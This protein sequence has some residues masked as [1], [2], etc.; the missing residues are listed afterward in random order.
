MFFPLIFFAVMRLLRQRRG[1]VVA[2]LAVLA[3]GSLVWAE[4]A[5]AQNADVAF[6]LPQYRAWELL[7]GAIASFAVTTGR[8]WER[9]LPS[10]GLIA[11][12]AAA[13]LFSPTTTPAPGASMLVPVLGT[14]AV[15]VYGPSD[16]W[17]RRLLTLR[18][19]VFI[20]LISYSAYLVHQPV[21]AFIRVASLGEPNPWIFVAVLPLVIGLAWLSW[22]FIEVPFRD[23]NR[24]STRRLFAVLVPSMS[25][26]V[27]LGL[28]LHF[29]QGFPQRVFPHL[30]SQADV[31]VS[32]NERVRALTIGRSSAPAQPDIVVV[33]DSFGRDAVNALLEADPN[34]TGHIAY[35]EPENIRAP[36]T[37]ALVAQVQS[38]V[39]P[40]TMIVL[41][42]HD[43]TTAVGLQQVQ[44][45][46]ALH[47]RDLEALGTKSFG[48]NLNPF[49]R[50]P[51]T[52]RP[53]A[54]VDV[55][56]TVAAGN[57]EFAQAIP[58]YI[59]VIRLL[60][61]DGRTVPVFDQDGNLLS[62]DRNH[63]TRFG[64]VVL[65]Q[66]LQA[67]APQLFVR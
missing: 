62:P 33:G 7:I 37:P 2:A 32:Y 26:A 40:S 11:I 38:A 44:Q 64:A 10:A 22:R 9:F 42:M 5:I 39:S 49:G 36:F 45:L 23:R 12:V 54:R 24:V 21:F 52:E 8:R 47:P 1:Q 61:G 60:G 46:N 25:V 67:A 13:V 48:W 65:G 58:H 34:L 20:G 43:Q 19:M 15:L 53:E 27:A 31:Y 4:I 56:P 35:A 51:L 29:S 55:L 17:A 14:A 57:D 3:V 6:Y 28:V 66:R 59:D 18:P 30:S 50:M 63:L 41:A 16:P